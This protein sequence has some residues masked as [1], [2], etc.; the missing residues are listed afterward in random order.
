MKA[1]NGY[2]IKRQI[3]CKCGEKANVR[4]ASIMRKDVKETVHCPSCKMWYDKW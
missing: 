1:A 2:E 3:D 4:N